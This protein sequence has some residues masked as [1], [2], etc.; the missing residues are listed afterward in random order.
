[1]LA[2]YEMPFKM[3]FVFIHS[4]SFIRVP[5]MRVAKLLPS[6][7]TFFCLTMDEQELSNFIRSQIAFNHTRQISE[8]FS[9]H[10]C[11]N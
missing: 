1:M 2:Y 3:L 7:N 11:N 9:I 4:F 6:F 5:T 8:N 10:L